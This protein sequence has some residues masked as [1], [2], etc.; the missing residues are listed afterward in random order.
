MDSSW[1]R[2][3]KTNEDRL[4][5]KEAIVN[6]VYTLDILKSILEQE[7]S[8]HD[9]TS[10]EDYSIPNWSCYQADRNGYKRALKRFLNLINIKK[11]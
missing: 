6:S 1:L 11:D 10:I 8:E 9:R 4:K 2:H 3:T 5:V 7:L